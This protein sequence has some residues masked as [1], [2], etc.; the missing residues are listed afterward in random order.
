MQ[1]IS[2]LNQNDE[3]LAR[4]NATDR[5]HTSPL[6]YKLILGVIVALA[7][8][9]DFFRLTEGGY[10]NLYYAA[11][12]SSMANNWHNFLYASFDPG[13]FVTIDKP[14]L[15]FWIQVASV[16]LF[17]FSPF[18]TLLPQALAGVLSVALLA[19]LVRR[20]AGPLAGLLAG[21]MLA[22]TPISVVTNRNLTMDSLLVL[23][24][25]LAAWCILTA[26]STQKLRFLLLGMV[27]VGLGFNIKMLEAYLCVPA[28]GLVYWFSCRQ[29]WKIRLRHLALA[30]G[31]LLAVSF[32]WLLFV[33][34]TPAALRPFVGSST[35]NSAFQL[36]FFYN[37]LGRAIGNITDPPSHQLIVSMAKET[38]LIQYLQENVPEATAAFSIGEPGLLRMLSEPL[39]WQI[40]WFMPLTLLGMLGVKWD[41]PSIWPLNREQQ[42]LALWGCWFLTTF[43]LFSSA[44][45]FHPHY[46][47][48]VAPSI[49]ALVG[50]GISALWQ[51][52]TRLSR[53]LLALAC[54]GTIVMQ[55]ALCCA[56][57]PTLAICW[58]ILPLLAVAF[59]IAVALWLKQSAPRVRATLIAVLLLLLA[60]CPVIW[61]MIPIMQDRNGPFPFAGPDPQLPRLQQLI[62][63]LGSQLTP[64]ASLIHYLQMHQGRARYITATIDAPTAASI[65]LA[66]GEPVMTLGG[67]TGYDPILRSEQLRSLVRNS[68]VRFFVLPMTANE[69]N[70][71]PDAQ[72]YLQDMQILNNV[73]HMTNKTPEWDF[74]RNDCRK[75]PQ[76]VWDS[77]DATLHQHTTLLDLYDCSG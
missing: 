61:S 47:V 40:G 25:L 71:S 43:I 60:T 54:A 4:T 35:N 31:L 46:T 58:L 39:G 33:D 11:G 68:T 24:S 9:L 45:F 72:E 49:C 8:F 44:Q 19:H 12:I 55:Y 14:P 64:D 1:S 50:I 7:S 73:Q 3:A 38:K 32:C 16:K 6:W 15:A 30:T 41:K 57:L 52:E 65:I 34:L 62:N 63:R 51:G 66:T 75:V 26:A 10:S 70:L 77:A 22:I 36:A 5:Q 18:S 13:G 69:S 42:G 27:V 23:T 28:F 59:L 53:R 48:M 29:P 21:A 67:Y 20:T 56:A 2:I 17:G 76:A 74:V 37:G